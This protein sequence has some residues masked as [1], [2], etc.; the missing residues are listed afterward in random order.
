MVT[1]SYSGENKYMN[2]NEINPQGI[3]QK[4]N[5]N[6]NGRNVHSTFLLHFCM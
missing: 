4:S 3:K 1:V 5:N 6:I 2:K